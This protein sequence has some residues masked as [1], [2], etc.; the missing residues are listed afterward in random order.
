MISGSETNALAR[1]DLYFRMQYRMYTIQLQKRRL[2]R[3][4]YL[5]EQ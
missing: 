5:N 3:I 2:F 1:R 4:A